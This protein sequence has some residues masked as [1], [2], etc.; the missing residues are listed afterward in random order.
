MNGAPAKRTLAVVRHAK[1][2]RH[3]AT[4]HGRPLTER[5]L[6]QAQ[7]T[8]AWLATELAG[9]SPDDTAALVSSATRAQQTWDEVAHHVAVTVRV[10]PGLYGAGTS[11]V[12]TTVQ[13]VEPDVATVVLVGHNPT[14]D[15][16]VAQLTA[17][18]DGELAAQVRSG[19]LSTGEAVL[20]DVA[21][22]WS[23]LPGSVSGV[24]AVHRP[25]A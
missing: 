1:A 9:A 4:D 7:D 8:A 25:R 10:L 22:D 24:R 12:L 21:G 3:A 17:E 5:G 2:E 23:R 20:L 6:H 15:E 16:L 18:D 13:M 11:E 19:G 14:L